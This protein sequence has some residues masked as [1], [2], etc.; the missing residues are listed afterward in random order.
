MDATT[1]ADTAVADFMTSKRVTK[2]EALIE[3]YVA[4]HKS[5]KKAEGGADAPKGSS[6]GKVSA[7][8]PTP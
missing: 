1:G 8:A 3:S 7:T 6:K 5:M 4:K 2:V